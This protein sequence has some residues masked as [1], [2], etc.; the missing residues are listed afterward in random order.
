MAQTTSIPVTEIA[1]FQS[2]G[3]EGAAERKPGFLSMP[4]IRGIH[5]ISV[6]VFGMREADLANGTVVAV[7]LPEAP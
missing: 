4:W 2:L 5:P 3:S 7:G 1:R 6:S